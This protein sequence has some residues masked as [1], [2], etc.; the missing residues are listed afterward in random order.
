MVPVSCLSGGEQA[1]LRPL[2]LLVQAAVRLVPQ[3]LLCTLGVQECDSG[4][5]APLGRI[6]LSLRGSPLFPSLACSAPHPIASLL[7]KV[8]SALT[9]SQGGTVS[10]V[11]L[12]GHPLQGHDLPHLPL[13][14]AQ[15]GV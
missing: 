14:P 3:L 1:G 5:R 4:Q 10:W 11:F 2:A 6:A 12:S 9:C 7:P 8:G 15:M 13:A